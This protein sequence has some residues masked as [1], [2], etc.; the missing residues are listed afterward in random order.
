MNTVIGRALR[1]AQDALNRKAE[2]IQRDFNAVS[3]SLR[4]VGRQLVD[5][6]ETERQPLLAEQAGLLARQQA[7][8][9][10][11]NLWRDRARTVLRQPSESALRAYL[12]DL[13][14]DPDETVLAAVDFVLRVLDASEAELAAMEQSAAQARP[15][16]PAGRLIERAR[17]EH[18]L[19]GSDAAARWRTAVEFANRPGLAQSDEALAELEAALSDPDP[20]VQETLLLTLMQLHRFRALRLAELDRVHASVERLA[21]MR[22]P[23]AIPILVEIA[24]TPRSGYLPGQNGPVEGN[25]S[26]SRAI[27]LIR[28][29]EWH[30]PEARAA[31]RGRLQDR[32]RHIAEA[33]ARLLQLSPGEW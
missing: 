12:A 1:Q 11:V 2:A 30:T 6:P 21:R 10:D 25:N 27:A 26:H 33:A 7:L 5:A 17:T 28:L 23:A 19:R 15:T 22:H 29:A 9:E 8:A 32:D 31:L 3:E 16:T 13:R 4:A 14:G 18:D 20:L 24:Q